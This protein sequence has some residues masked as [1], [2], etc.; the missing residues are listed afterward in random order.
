MKLISTLLLICGFTSALVAQT[1]NE[2]I[3]KRTTYSNTFVLENGSK[4]TMISGEPVN[5]LDNGDWKQVN[6]NFRK[7][8]NQF[9]NTTNSIISKF[10]TQTVSGQYITYQNEEKSFQVNSTKELVFLNTSGEIQ[11]I[12]ISMQSVSGNASNN[13]I[14]YSNIF[15]SI[16]DHYTAEYGAVKHEFILDELP[17]YVQSAHGNYFGFREEFLLP[18]GWTIEASEFSSNELIE[19][20]LKIK[21]ETGEQLF[22]VPV[23]V[24]YES[25]AFDSDGSS[26][27]KGAFQI[28]QN[29]NTWFVSTLVPTE[30]LVDPMTQYPVII[31][32]TVT[33]TLNAL[34]GGWQSQNNYVDNNGYV[35]IGVCCGNLEH[36]AWLKWDVSS[37][38]DNACVT[39]AE[40]LVYVN[41]VGGS[42]AE[43]VHVYDMM[44]TTTTG[45]FGPYGAILPAV[46]ADQ[47]NGY[48]TSFTITG[49]G[50]Y[51]WYDLGANACSDIMTMMNSYDLF[52]VAIIFDNEPSTN[53]KRMTG[54]LCQLRITYDTNPPCAPLPITLGDYDMSCE[55]GRAVIDWSTASEQN[56]DFFTIWESSDGVEF[57]EIAKVDGQGNSISTTNYQWSSPKDRAMNNYYRISQTDFDGTTKMLVTGS[58]DDCASEKA[59]VF[60]NPD[61]NIE[62]KG[63]NI[64]SIT[65]LDQ[66]GRSV[67]D[68]VNNEAKSTI[69]LDELNIVHGVYNAIVTK[70]NG[71]TQV[72]RF[73][74]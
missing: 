41:G 50:Y 63:E 69:I 2:L 74:F 68:R 35:F 16:H 51:S 34:T 45:L 7:E 55:N 73:V 10:P 22:T 57:N 31:D 48:Y 62:I 56:N 46:Y 71:E 1:G 59:I 21:D 72:V 52:Q 15:P 13:E 8:K 37:I 47:G 38:P 61:D 42:A 11:A 28:N 27:M 17:A 66:M 40:L 26:K 4:E 39:K 29:G 33:T 36:R 23:P 14:N 19:S 54:N 58:V 65:I 12:N 64:Q 20:S 9:V 6:V 30:W 32:P 25:N 53:W 3:Q 43:L 67:L 60:I 70:K 49:T 44:A 5:Y 24:Y 18:E